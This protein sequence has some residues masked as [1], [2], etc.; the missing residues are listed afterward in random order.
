MNKTRNFNSIFIFALIL[1]VFVV[2]LEYGSNLFSSNSNSYNLSKLQSDVGAGKVRNV[3]IMPNAETPTGA[4]RVSFNDGSD[5]VV[6]Y[7]TD[8]TAVESLLTELGIGVEVKDI[9]SE[10]SLCRR[11][12]TESLAII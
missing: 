5:D 7:T 8:V 9:P 2:V 6:F 11:F 10:E 12:L 3:V 1:L 4:A